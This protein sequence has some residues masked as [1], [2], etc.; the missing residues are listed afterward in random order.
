MKVNTV[1]KRFFEVER[2][3]LLKI[4]RLADALSRLNVRSKNRRKNFVAMIQKNPSSN[5]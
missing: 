2:A 4:A 5:D 1:G 3:Y